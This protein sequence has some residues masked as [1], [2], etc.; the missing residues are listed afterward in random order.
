MCKKRVLSV[1][2]GACLLDCNLYENWSLWVFFSQ[3]DVKP[4]TFLSLL[5]SIWFSHVQVLA[6]KSSFL[7]TEFF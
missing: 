5:I 1:S 2:L 3:P 6:V 4:L 7:L